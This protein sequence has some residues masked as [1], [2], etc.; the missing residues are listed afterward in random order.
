MENFQIQTQSKQTIELF[1]NNY[2]DSEQTRKTYEEI[3]SKLKE[4]FSIFFIKK[5]K[6]IPGKYKIAN[7]MR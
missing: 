7:S 3:N 4:V 6:I 2:N 5:F 1:K